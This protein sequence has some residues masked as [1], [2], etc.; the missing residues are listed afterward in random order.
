MR[1]NLIFSGIP[2]EGQFREK[3]KYCKEVI[4]NL[5]S[6]ELQIPDQISIDRAHRLGRFNPRHAYP[7]PKVAK[8]T[9]FKDKERVREAAPKKLRDT[10]IWVKEQ[11]PQEIELKRKEL[12]EPAKRARQDP[13]NKVTL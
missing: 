9:Y 13:N 5:I 6:T 10:N 7:R 8:F 1:D 11:Y 12:Y 4:Q 3:G 2:E